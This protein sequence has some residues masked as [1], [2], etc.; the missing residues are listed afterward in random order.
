MCS[1][2]SCDYAYEIFF[3]YRKKRKSAK[4]HTARVLVIVPSLKMI[5]IWWKG[6][7]LYIIHITHGKAI[8]YGSISI[9]LSQMIVKCRCIMCSIFFKLLRF[10]HDGNECSPLEGLYRRKAKWWNIEMFSKRSCFLKIK[11]LN[12][13]HCMYAICGMRYFCLA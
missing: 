5:Q 7:G 8:Q 12:T 4:R 10:R 6:V 2:V 3:S 13:E 9:S 1:K 11:V